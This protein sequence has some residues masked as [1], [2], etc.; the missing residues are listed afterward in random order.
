MELTSP[1]ICHICD[2]SAKI[3]YIAWLFIKFLFIPGLGVAFA[4]PLP[5]VIVQS[6]SMHHTADFEQWWQ[7]REQLYANYNI[8]KEEFLRFKLSYGFDVGDIII[9]KGYRN[10]KP[11]IGDIIIFDAKQPLP[12]IHRVVAIHDSTY[13]TLGDKNPAQLSFEKDI[14]QEQIFGKAVARIPKIG[15]AKLVFVLPFRKLE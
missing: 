3:N 7:G 6:S 8:S 11:K 10:S 14:T 2:T 15:W 4:T 1:P 9:V 5:S 13:E 12:I